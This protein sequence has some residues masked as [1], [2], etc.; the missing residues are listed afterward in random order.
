MFAYQKDKRFFAQVGRGLDELAGEELAE[1]GARDIENVGNGLYF[2]AD[3]A[4]LYRV[5]YC[6]RLLSRVLAP[7]VS[8]P[9][10]ANQVLYDAALSVDWQRILSLGQTFAVFAHV[11]ESHITHAHYAALRLKDA[12]VDHFRERSG[13]RP[14]VD[15]EHPDVW[16][17]LAIRRDRA[18]ISL[19]TSGG[20]LHRRGY[21]VQSVAAPLQETLAAALV[22]LS[23]WHGERPL[24]DPM[25]GSG[26]IVTEAFMQYCRLPAALKRKK[27]G[28]EVM[29][30][31][32]AGTWENVRRE[33]DAAI[34]PL[35][36]QLIAGSDSDRQAIDAARRNLREIPGTRGLSLT[37]KDFHDLAYI[38]DATI[39]CNPPYGM[40]IGALEPTRFLYKELGDFL[41]Q[42]CPGST[43]YVLC[44][45]RELIPAIGLKPARRFV[46]FNGPIEC[47]LL[48]IEIY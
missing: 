9:C 23:G 7:L 44:G 26:T 4:T 29:P 36:D 16:I 31:Y 35:P 40:R 18:Q 41:K 10:P 6:S 24:V 17:N 45:N 20:S 43:A 11:S 42:R 5:N 13:R 38:R 2:V 30:D 33:C 21:R 34:R 47:R 28:F 48:K 27:F 46:L 8:F 15:S 39:I 1:L 22:R 3:A 19:D 32:D 12:I 25:C 37:R 14:D